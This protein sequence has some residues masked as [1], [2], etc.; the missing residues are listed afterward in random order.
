[1]PI[2][3]NLK[4]DFDEGR[5]DSLRSISFEDTGTKAPYVTNPEGSSP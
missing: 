1:M 3:R 5:M 4:K 2:I